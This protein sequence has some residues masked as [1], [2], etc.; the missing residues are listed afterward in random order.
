ML[1]AHLRREIVADGASWDV[2]AVI[3]QRE[4]QLGSALRGED[5]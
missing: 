3:Q 4:W 5:A 2:A 1:L